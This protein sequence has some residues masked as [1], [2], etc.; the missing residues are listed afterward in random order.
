MQTRQMMIKHQKY[1][2]LMLV[3]GCY[4]VDQDHRRRQQQQ[5]SVPNK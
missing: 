5:Q 1:L 3:I 2:T 4:T